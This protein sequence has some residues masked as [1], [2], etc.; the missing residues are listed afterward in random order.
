M[1]TF[2][3]SELEHTQSFDPK[4]DP[5]AESLNTTFN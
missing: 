2:F 4:F 5:D 3:Y 1:I